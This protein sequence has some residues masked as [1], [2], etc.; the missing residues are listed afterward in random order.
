M[1][2]RILSTVVAGAAI[3]SF[4]SCG[5]PVH[6]DAVAALGEDPSGEHEGPLHRAGQPCLTCHGELGP[7]K[8]EFAIA[9]TVYKA[10]DDRTGVEGAIVTFST[11]DN[12][13]VAVQTN[14]VGSFY[15]SKSK[16]PLRFPLHVSISYP[17]L[18]GEVI[19]AS[20]I[21]RAGSCA[22]C[23]SDPSSREQFGHIYLVATAAEWP[24][25]P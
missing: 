5:S 8:P 12:D 20:R 6:D 14:A 13:A 10:I 18:P 24:K 7:A 19:M 16:F 15:V 21:G 25:T 17:G 2:R 23:H 3:V 11:L 4:L 22:D 1:I 9:G